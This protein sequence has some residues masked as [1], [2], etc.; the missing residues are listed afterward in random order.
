MHHDAYK[1]FCKWRG[2]YMWKFHRNIS[3]QNMTQYKRFEDDKKN[4]TDMY[5]NTTFFP[6]HRYKYMHHV[7]FDPE[8]RC[9]PAHAIKLPNFLQFAQH[10]LCS[11]KYSSHDLQV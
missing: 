7:F 4:L 5:T 3:E 11:S 2:K 10:V 8:K 9:P 6:G 1:Y